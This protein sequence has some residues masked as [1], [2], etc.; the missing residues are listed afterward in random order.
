MFIGPSSTEV[1]EK[2]SL[3]DLLTSAA[4]SLQRNPQI[5]FLF[6]VPSFVCQ[7]SPRHALFDCEEMLLVYHQLLSMPSCHVVQKQAS[8]QLRGGLIL[9]HLLFDYTKFC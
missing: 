2:Y 4:R 8:F 6:T 7:L 1:L 3:R 5:V 9:L